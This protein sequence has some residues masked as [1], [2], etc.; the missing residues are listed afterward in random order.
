[1]KPREHYQNGS[2]RREARKHGAAVWTL[3]WRVV[4]A[5]GGTTR[6]K[7]VIGTVEEYRTKASAL[8]ACEFLRS[9]INKETRTPR[10]VAELVEHYR[11]K[12][13]PTKTPYTREVYEGY[14]TKWIAPMWETS[15][16]SD[17]RTVVGILARHFATV[18][19]ITGK[20][21]EHHVSNLRARDEMGISRSKP[22]HPGTAE[23][24]A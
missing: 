13:L 19:W 24:E 21:S 7:A 18:Q 4:N 1:M 20:G 2:I 10:T 9:T 14:I 3:R 6:R 15:S 5:N 22:D 12:E 23:R 11:E 8:K 17:V 16:L